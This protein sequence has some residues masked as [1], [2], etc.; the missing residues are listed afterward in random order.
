MLATTSDFN[1]SKTDT[2]F[3]PRVSLSWYPNPQQH[4]YASYSQGFKGGS[5]DP[6]AQTTGAPDL[7][8]DGTVS[9][10][11]IFAFMS[12]D[13]ETVSSYELGIKSSWLD[14]RCQ[15]VRHYNRNMP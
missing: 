13:P 15:R 2:D 5:F 8:G 9:P 4:I 12:F 6:R 7:D 10:E 3:S 14:N 11:E 1:G